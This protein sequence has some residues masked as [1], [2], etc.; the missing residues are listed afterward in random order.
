MMRIGPKPSTMN[1]FR[2]DAGNGMSTDISSGN[3]PSMLLTKK[4]TQKAA[5]IRMASLN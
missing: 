4:G 2:S 5:K 1:I 3:A